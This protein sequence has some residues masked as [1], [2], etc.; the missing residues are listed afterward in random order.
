MLKLMNKLID[1][2]CLKALLND[3]DKVKCIKMSNF[4]KGNFHIE[5]QQSI[6]DQHIIVI[7]TDGPLNDD[8]LNALSHMKQLEVNGEEF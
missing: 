5:T 8:H 2:E 3:M 4:E 1:Y 7:M 6:K